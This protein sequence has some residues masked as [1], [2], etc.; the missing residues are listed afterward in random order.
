M[1]PDIHIAI[2]EPLTRA[3]FELTERETAEARVQG[4]AAR[5]DFTA[6]L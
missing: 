2:R 1:T 6:D 3:H 4:E 5:S